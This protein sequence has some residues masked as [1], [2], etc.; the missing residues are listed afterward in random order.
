MNEKLFRKKSLDRVS[1][2]EQLDSYIRVS[3]PG[4]WMLLTAIAVLLVGVCVWGVLGHLDTTVP[5]VA[6]V[7]DGQAT[8][9][10]KEAD[11][12]AL[13]LGMTVRLAEGEY[14][15]TAIPAQPIA[16]DGQFSEY[17]CHVGDLRQGEWVYAVSVSGAPADGIYTAQIVTESVRPM[18]FVI[19]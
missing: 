14:T 2:P 13:A 15:I 12:G 1:S 5:A 9:Y 17:A 19:N 6:V 3:N 7:T 11:A 4:V 16:V 8:V 10:V 18:S